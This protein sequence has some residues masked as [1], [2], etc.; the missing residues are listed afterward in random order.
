[1]ITTIN[2]LLFVFVLWPLWV[3]LT[4]LK[5]SFVFFK[6]IVDAAEF[7][8]SA[9][10]LRYRYDNFDIFDFLLEILGG[11]LLIIVNTFETLDDFHPYFWDFAKYNHPNWAFFISCISCFIWSLF[12]NN[13]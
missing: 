12:L 10:I 11:A 9:A 7:F 6:N 1:M 8:Y 13:E 2:A 5:A 3:G 4:L